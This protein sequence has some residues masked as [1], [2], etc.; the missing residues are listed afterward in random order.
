MIE[1]HHLNESRSRRVT[2]LLE[3]LGVEYTVINYQRDASTR[4]APPELTAVH[5]LAWMPVDA[6]SL[7]LS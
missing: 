4:L 2:W 7:D 5:P 6:M 1:L 3:E